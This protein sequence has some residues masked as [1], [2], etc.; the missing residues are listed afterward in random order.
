MQDNFKEHID[1]YIDEFDHSFDVN[2]GWSEFQKKRA[3]KNRLW[4][5]SAAASITSLLG[6]LGVNF[7]IQ[8][9]EPQQLSE[10]DEVELFYQAQIDNMTRLV[11]NVTD[12]ES[13]LFDLEEMDRAFAEVKKDLQDDAANEEVIEAMMNH[14]RLKLNILQKMLE[15]I[16]EEDETNESTV[17]L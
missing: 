2:K 12:D 5:W 14:Y 17:I 1:K 15:E 9:E 13:I 4:I 11:R 16:K 10:W 6:I 8:T 3:P 7:M